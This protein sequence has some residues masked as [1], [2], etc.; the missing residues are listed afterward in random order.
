M[1]G[2]ARP[3]QSGMSMGAAARAGALRPGRRASGVP[4]KPRDSRT[5]VPAAANPRAP[6]TT[7]R[8]RRMP[9][10]GWGIVLSP[11]A[12]PGEAA[13]RGG[14]VVQQKNFLILQNPR[15]GLGGFPVA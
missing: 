8:A 4:A 1:A 5:I 12:G 7:R 14:G 2:R 9:A 3:G 11:S 10:G 15:L 13:E 6:T